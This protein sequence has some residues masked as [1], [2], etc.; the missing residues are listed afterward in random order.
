MG[1][2]MHNQNNQR[3]FVSILSVIFFTLL[4]SVLTIG[5]LRIMTDEQTQVV[6]NDL[7]KSAL[8]S[9]ESGVED[10][11]RALVY[12][13]GLS[14]VA[15]TT[16]YQALNNQS[17][18]G[19]FDTGFPG[20][21]LPS[22]LGLD[23]SGG[24]G[25]V[26]V[27]SQVNNQR[28]TCVT[29]DLETENVVGQASETLGEFIPLRSTSPF[30]RVTVY[31]HQQGADGPAALPGAG[32]TN[33]NYRY[34][35]WKNSVTNQRFVAV[36][37]LQLVAFDRNQT[38]TQMQDSS[39]GMFLHPMSNTGYNTTSPRLTIVNPAGPSWVGRT[40]IVDARVEVRCNTG[41]L[42]KG[43]VC[44]MSMDVPQDNPADTKEYYMLVKS[45]YGSPHYMLEI[46]QTG[47][48]VMFNDV[49]PR[50]DSTGAAADVFRRVISRVSYTADAFNTTNALE[51]GLSVCKDYLVTDIAV[52]S[53]GGCPLV[54]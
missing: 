44:A 5:F 13:R 46:S 33:V 10:A 43:F 50:I 17:C 54:P 37:R 21:P 29:T 12:C 15:R 4:M 32:D 16:C 7:S 22:A 26:R 31:W 19:M 6:D 25:A 14:G 1:N 18:P 24:G 35:E 41:T 47:S 8:A 34:S 27:G 49:Q 36:L 42:Q 53:P 48:P 23:T 20:N 39:V 45:L 30:N 28:Y 51:S 52:S 40:S 38:L 9:A 2:T 11:K 3:G